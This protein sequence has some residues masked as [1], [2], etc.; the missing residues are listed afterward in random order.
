M[1]FCFHS[2]FLGGR[3]TTWVQYRNARTT[4]NAWSTKR[5]V[6]RAR[7]A[8]CANACWWACLRADRDTVA[9]L[10][11]SR[12]TVCYR[13]KMRLRP[14]RPSATTRSTITTSTTMAATDH[15]RTTRS[16]STTSRSRRRSVRPCTRR[17]SYTRATISWPPTSSCRPGSTVTGPPRP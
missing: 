10:T 9:G 8:G 3:T 15:H 12:S 13:T 7:R 17:A 4:A 1:L 6:L 14:Q 5:T 16:S 11:G 2:R